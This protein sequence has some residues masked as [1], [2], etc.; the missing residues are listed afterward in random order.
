[1][2]DWPWVATPT[3]A[4]T[5]LNSIGGSTTDLGQSPL[6]CSTILSRIARKRQS[7]RGACAL[8][9]SSFGRITCKTI[10]HRP[11][12]RET[13]VGAHRC[14]VSTVFKNYLSSGRVSL[15]PVCAG[16]KRCCLHMLSIGHDDASPQPSPRR[17]IRRL[18]PPARLSVLAGARQSLSPVCGENG[19]DN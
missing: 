9:L 2:P 6:L 8:R 15:K 11:N 19:C 7:Q 16:L 4:S 10:L 1:M 14:A 17:P 5:Q 12:D 18:R 13:Y 3:V